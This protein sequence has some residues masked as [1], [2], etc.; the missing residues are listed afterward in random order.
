MHNDDN[1]DSIN[2]VVSVLRQQ[3]EQVP[4]CSLN[5][6]SLTQTDQTVH[7]S[8][9]DNKAKHNSEYNYDDNDTNKNDNDDNKQYVSLLLKDGPC[10]LGQSFYDLLKEYDTT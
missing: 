1:N 3:D 5:R 4:T 7:D 10:P 6:R 2:D 9:N 8:M